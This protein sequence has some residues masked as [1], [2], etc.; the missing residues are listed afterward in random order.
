FKPH[1]QNSQSLR[2]SVQ[3]RFIPNAARKSLGSPRQRGILAA[4]GI[5]RYSLCL[6]LYNEQE[7]CQVA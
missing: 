1:S 6:Y 2:G 3:Q 5:K 4:L 7:L